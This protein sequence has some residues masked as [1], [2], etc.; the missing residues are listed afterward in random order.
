MNGL[1]HFISA[2]DTANE[3]VGRIAL[4]LVPAMVLVIAYEVVARYFFGS[5][6]IWAYETTQFIFCAAI[7]LGGGYTLLHGRHVNVDIVYNRLKARPRAILDSITLP[8]LIA[9]IAILFKFTI[10]ATI[11]G[12]HNEEHSATY[13]APPLVPIYAVMMAGVFLFLIQGVAN[14]VRSILIAVTGVEIKSRY[15]ETAK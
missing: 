9:F 6:T 12:L 10:D 11:E 14:W 2:I 4:W 15:A 5:P 1:K 8:F 7:A 3:H 13:W